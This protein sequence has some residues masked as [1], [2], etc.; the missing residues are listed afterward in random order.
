MVICTLDIGADKQVGYFG[1]DR[2][3]N[4]ALGYR[5]IRI[6]LT[7]REIFKQQLRAILRAGAYGTVSVMFPM[8]ISPEEV[9]QAKALLAECREELKRE[10][11][12]AG[13]WR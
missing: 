8:I 10:G 13:P 9:R 5:A 2:E 4:P 3:E 6:C 7:R 12:A 11:T 1:L